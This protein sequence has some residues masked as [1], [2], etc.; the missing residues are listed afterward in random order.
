MGWPDGGS[1]GGGKAKPKSQKVIEKPKQA[2][3]SCM[4]ARVSDKGEAIV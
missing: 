1:I 4:W 3:E 2:Q